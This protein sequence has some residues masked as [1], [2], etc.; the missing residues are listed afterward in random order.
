MCT[1]PEQFALSQ[2]FPNPFNP[3]TNFEFR[4]ADFGLASLKV[5]D[6]FGR[7]IATPVNRELVPGVHRATWDATGFP[8]GVYFYSLRAGREVQTR[9]LVLVK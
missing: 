1:V 2:N 8:S 5:Y 4:V 6:M 7:E 9:K 3:S